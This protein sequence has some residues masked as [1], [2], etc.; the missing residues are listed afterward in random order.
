MGQCKLMVLFILFFGLQLRADHYPSCY[1]DTLPYFSNVQRLSGNA[2]EKVLVLKNGCR[3]FNN[4][5]NTAGPGVGATVLSNVI[6][7]FSLPSTGQATS[8]FATVNGNE[9]QRAFRRRLDEIRQN[10][11]AMD[12]IRAVYELVARAQGSYDDENVN[13]LR[14]ASPGGAIDRAATQGSAGVCRD[15][16]LFLQW[17]LMQVSRHPSSRGMALGPT[18]FSSEVKGGFMP[19]G[20][21]A[22]VR[23]NLPNHNAQGQLL[24]FN[25]FDIDTTWYP[26]Q[27]SVLFP[28]LSSLNSANR[29][30]LISQCASVTRCLQTFA[31]A[32]HAASPRSQRISNPSRSKSGVRQ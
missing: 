9:R 28:R 19:A 15:F 24:G 20:G 5:G 27:F 16:A 29:T 18:D 14:Y 30:R 26:E 17:S 10:P 6:E 22:W 7:N 12:R 11:N 13:G 2:G 4:V 25:R 8:A 21:H 32:E 3:E 1:R 31:S 23:V